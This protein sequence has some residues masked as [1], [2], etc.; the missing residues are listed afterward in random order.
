MA[1]LKFILD[2]LT[3]QGIE[4]TRIYFSEDEICDD[5]VT[6]TKGFSI[7]VGSNYYGLWHRDKNGIHTDF[8]TFTSLKSTINTIKQ[9]LK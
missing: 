1:N 7:Q 6:L 4:V 9:E 2:K 8:G 5:E 3:A